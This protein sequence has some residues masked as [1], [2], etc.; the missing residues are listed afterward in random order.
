MS[1]INFLNIIQVI[2][3]V[4][5]I[6]FILI[7]RGPGA[8]AGSAFGSGASGTVFGAKGSASFLSKTTAILATAFFIVTMTI[9]INASN[10]F[11]STGD[12]AEQDL[13]VMGTLDDLDAEPVMV[14]TDEVQTDLNDVVTDAATT[15][16][17]TD[18]AVEPAMSKV[19]EE[20]PEVVEETEQ[21]DTESTDSDGDGN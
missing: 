6:I 14:P 1:E 17:I 21:D 8:T 19:D 3:A 9:A 12:Q 2:V 13:G 4:A 18:D 5:L 11:A 10:K 20:L 15:T 16:E 7:Q